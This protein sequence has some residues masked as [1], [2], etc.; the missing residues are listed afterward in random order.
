MIKW[1]YKVVSAYGLDEKQLNAL[2]SEGWELIA[3]VPSLFLGVSEETEF[4]FKRKVGDEEEHK[5]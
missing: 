5:L 3:L 4:I 2:G 1:K